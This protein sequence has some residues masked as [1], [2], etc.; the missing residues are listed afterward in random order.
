MKLQALLTECTKYWDRNRLFCS[1][2]FCV[3][4]NHVGKAGIFFFAQKIDLLLGFRLGSLIP[5]HL[6]QAVWILYIHTFLKYCIFVLFS[7]L[8]QCL[9]VQR[10][11]ENSCAKP[12]NSRTNSKNII[13]DNVSDSLQRIGAK[14][15]SI[16]A[17]Q[18]HCIEKKS[19]AVVCS[20]CSCSREPQ[21]M[22]KCL[23]MITQE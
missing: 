12:L 15:S 2:C 16:K 4:I 13:W 21:T 7:F 9:F 5:S 20:L 23:N 8:F 19:S 14:C 11:R 17:W 22:G 18:E 6:S 10:S 1:G 3:L